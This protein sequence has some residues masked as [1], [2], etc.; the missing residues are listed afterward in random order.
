MDLYLKDIG[1]V[2][3]DKT[4]HSIPYRDGAKVAP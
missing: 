3:S 2:V 4:F 1:F